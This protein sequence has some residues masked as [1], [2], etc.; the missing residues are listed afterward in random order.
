MQYIVA[1]FIITFSPDVCPSSIPTT[2]EFGRTNKSNVMCAVYHIRQDS[3]AHKKVFTHKDSATVFYNKLVA[4]TKKQGG[5]I[6][7]GSSLISSVTI[8]TDN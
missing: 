7:I 5:F 8:K 1:W 4:E 6:G 2:D 3:T